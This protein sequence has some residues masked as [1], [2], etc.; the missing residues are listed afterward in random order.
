MRLIYKIT[1]KSINS[2]KVNTKNPFH[3]FKAFWM[4]LLKTASLWTRPAVHSFVGSFNCQNLQS[5]FIYI[6]IE[7]QTFRLVRFTIAVSDFSK[8]FFFVDIFH[9]KPNKEKTI[10]MLIKVKVMYTFRSFC[11]YCDCSGLV[12]EL[13]CCCIAVYSHQSQKIW[14]RF[15]LTN[16]NSFFD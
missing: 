13:M 1:K 4:I 7:I 2:K 9:W 16:S 15:V 8:V 12:G 6:Q 3:T 14:L 5:L 11:D 10:N